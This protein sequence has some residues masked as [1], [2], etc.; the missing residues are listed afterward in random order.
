MPTKRTFYLQRKPH[1]SFCYLL[2]ICVLNMVHKYNCH[3]FN[4]QFSSS[5]NFLPLLK[6]IV[7]LHR[8]IPVL[9][10]VNEN[11]FR[12]KYDQYDCTKT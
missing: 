12:L 5:V 2:Q 7:K 3:Y 1:F 11:T 10:E 8:K 9:D 4:E 6:Q